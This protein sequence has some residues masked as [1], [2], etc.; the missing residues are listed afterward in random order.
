MKAIIINIGDEL[1]IGQ[2]TNF[3]AS[4]MAEQLNSIGVDVIRINVISD[5]EAEIMNALKDAELV[6]DVVLITGGL[7]PTNDDIT[8]ETLCKYFNTRLIFD[9]NIFN[10]IAGFFKQRGFAVTETNR[11]QSEVPEGCIVIRNPQGTAPGLWLE[12]DEKIFVAMPGVPYEMKSIMTD[13]II[14]MI[15]KRLTGNTIVHKTILTQG[16]GESFLADKIAGWENNLPIHIRLAYLP[17]PGIVKLRLTARGK[18]KKSLNKEIEEQVQK[19]HEIISE[20]IY[21]YDP[22]TIEQIIGKLLTVKRKTL[23][24]AESCTGGYI[25]HCITKIP[26]SS[27]YFKGSMIAYSNEIKE[28]FL[29]IP[30]ETLISHGAVSE[31]TV[32]EMAENIRRKFNVDYS[33]AVSG[34]AGPDG[35]TP[36]KPVGLVWIA[37]ACADETILQKFQFGNNRMVNIERASVTALNMLRKII[38][39]YEEKLK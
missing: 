20:N 31:Q 28:N 14:P 37:V 29:D 5:T 2:V 36:E 11:K 39:K 7:G 12:K 15:E 33:I 24:T 9:E 1:L 23:A 10:D 34:I 22:E 19:L 25:A 16:V 3:N 38:L 18:N 32:K 17:S 21:G 4:W 27:V 26:G 8:K 30:M 13:S 6:A 35:G